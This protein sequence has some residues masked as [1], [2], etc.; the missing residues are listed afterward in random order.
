MGGG[1]GW[2]GSGKYQRSVRVMEE[3][4][5]GTGRF[6]NR[7]KIS[8]FKIYIIKYGHAKYILEIYWTTFS[9]IIDAVCVVQC[10]HKQISKHIHGNLQTLHRK[11]VNTTLDISKVTSKLKIIYT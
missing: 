4:V 7:F 9:V 1:G 3:N 5:S 11:I 8:A 10:F 2:R 6:K